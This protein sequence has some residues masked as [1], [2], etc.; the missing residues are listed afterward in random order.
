MHM[1]RNIFFPNPIMGLF[2]SM[3]GFSVNILYITSNLTLSID[4]TCLR[5]FIHYLNYFVVHWLAYPA[6][7]TFT[8]FFM[9]LNINSDEFNVLLFRFHISA[10]F[11]TTATKNTA[12]L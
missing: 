6:T 12:L 11:I 4:Q 2:R 7:C 5:I 9:N 1:Q 3:H 10:D 8:F